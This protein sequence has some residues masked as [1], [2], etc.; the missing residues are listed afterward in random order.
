MPD[1]KASCQCPSDPPRCAHC[2]IELSKRI[3]RQEK[4]AGPK[5]C[6][7]TRYQD[8]TSEAL[9]LL[10]NDSGVLEFS[11]QASIQESEGYG[12]KDLGYAHL[13]AEKPRIQEIIEFAQKMNFKRICLVFC[14]GLRK[15]AQIV[16]QIFS[17]NGFDVISVGC[18]AGGISK[19]E[20]DLLKEQQIDPASFETMCNPI[21]QALVA[22][23]HQSQFN[24]LLGLCVGHDSLFFK[25]AD[26]YTTVLAVKDRLLAHNPLAA[27]YNYDSYYRYLKKPI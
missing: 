23:H 16:S 17:D 2:T 5:N 25:Y 14:V 27:I 3:C 1:S 4:G 24:V 19:Q 10:K 22:N 8:L 12:H 11:R 7:S 18:K 21:L 20:I 15:E 13:R 9:T 6:P 26:A